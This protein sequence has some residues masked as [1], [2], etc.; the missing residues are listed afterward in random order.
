MVQ[1]GK[2][3]NDL[4]QCLISG[5][6][7]RD[8]LCSQVYV[9]RLWA[10]DAV[11]HV[12]KLSNM[13]EVEEKS[14]NLSTAMSIMSGWS[15]PEVEGDVDEDVQLEELDDDV[16]EK[17]AE[18][19]AEAHEMLLARMEEIHQQRVKV[20]GGIGTWCVGGKLVGKPFAVAQTVVLTFVLPVIL[21]GLFHVVIKIIGQAPLPFISPAFLVLVIFPAASYVGCC[22]IVAQYFLVPS[23]FSARRQMLMFSSWAGIAK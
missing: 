9:A 19:D 17:L 14:K 20:A 6:F 8:C 15:G 2:N 23:L 18:G 11:N 13:D 3:A 16:L 12:Y 22:Y 10:I 7:L 1:R 5:T 21:V 4:Q